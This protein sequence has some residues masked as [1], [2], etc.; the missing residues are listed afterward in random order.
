MAWWD[1]LGR[2]GCSRCAQRAAQAVYRLA[3]PAQAGSAHLQPC[4]Q[5]L[6]SWG[7][8]SRTVARPLGAEMSAR[9]R[10]SAVRLLRTDSCARPPDVSWLAPTTAREHRPVSCASCSRSA[11]GARRVKLVGMQC[12]MQPSFK[13]LGGLK[14]CK[15]TSTGVSSFACYQCRSQGLVCVPARGCLALE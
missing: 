11:A 7:K 10:S 13:Y 15:A 3:L 1:I 9:D 12:Q 4:R 14:Q 5:R 6:R 2:H 8:V